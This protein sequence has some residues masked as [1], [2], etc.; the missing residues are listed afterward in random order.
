MMIIIIF[1]YK[2]Y[3]KIRL[4]MVVNRQS[5]YEYWLW[6]VMRYR[7]EVASPL[8]NLLML[9]VWLD[10]ILD[11]ENVE[12]YEGPSI[13]YNYFN[14]FFLFIIIILLLLLLLLLFI[15]LNLQ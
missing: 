6:N 4:D 7:R 1:I 11:V 3:L 14:R 15:F 12:R 2:G 5:K 10:R 8:I 13:F 9:I